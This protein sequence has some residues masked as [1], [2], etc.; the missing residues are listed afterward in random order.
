MLWMVL[1]LLLCLVVAAAVAVYVAF[2]RR[3]EDVPHAPWLGDLMKRG[4]ASLP[5]IDN[6]ESQGRGQRIPE[7]RHGPD[8]RAARHPR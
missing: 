8:S 2:V 7:Q 1:I 3:G 6:L 5:T 4:V